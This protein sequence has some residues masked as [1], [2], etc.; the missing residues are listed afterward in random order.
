MEKV[1]LIYNSAAG[2]KRRLLFHSA[3][4]T[5]EDIKRLLTTYQIRTDYYPTKYP[6]H[7]VMLAR[8]GK[9]EGYDTIIAAGG[10]GTVSEVANGIIGTG[11]TMAILPLGTFMNIARM[12]SIPNDVEKAVMLLKIGRKRKID[13]GKVIISEGMVLKKPWY[14]L[15]TAGIGLDARLGFHFLDFEKGDLSS[16]VKIARSLL[17]FNS[18]KVSLI[19]DDKILKVKTTIVTVANGPYSGVS[20][21]IAPRAKLNDHRLTVTLYTMS[22]WQVLLYFLSTKLSGK[23]DKRRMSMYKTKKV[24]VSSEVPRLFHTDGRQ[25]GRTP[26]VLEIIP[27]ALDVISGYPR[28]EEETYLNKRTFLD[29]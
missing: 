7:A 11:L 3:K 14:F 29:P 12:L 20:L 28:Q 18:R 2:I 5:L 4:I 26:V 6:G 23:P 25:F 1:K 22:K 27:N 17:D 9:K 8:E 13:V 24:T 15:E 21:P 16:T 19:L 10:D